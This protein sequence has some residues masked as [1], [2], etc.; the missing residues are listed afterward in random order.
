MDSFR[1]LFT[2]KRPPVPTCG[3]D[4]EERDGLQTWLYRGLRYSDS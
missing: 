1:I 2:G 4:R 3:A